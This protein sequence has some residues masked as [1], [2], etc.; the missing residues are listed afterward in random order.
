MLLGVGITCKSWMARITGRSRRYL[1]QADL[2]AVRVRHLQEWKIIND[3]DESSTYV[4]LLYAS[5]P[6]CPDATTQRHV[7]TFPEP[8]HL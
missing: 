5:K 8:I 3:Y 7:M 4:P 6:S 2:V 1:Y